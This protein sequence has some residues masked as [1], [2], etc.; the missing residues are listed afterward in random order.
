ML[1]HLIFGVPVLEDGVRQLETRWGVRAQPGGH[2]QGLGTHNALLGLGEGAY[3][4]LIAPDPDQPPPPR[5]RPFGLDAL[6]HP[7]LVAWAVRADD[8]DR[9]VAH[10]RTQ[11]YDPGDPLELQRTTARGTP[12][13]WRLTP[14]ALAGGPIPFLI[15]WGDAIHPSTSAPTGLTLVS[16]HL[17]HPQPE[18][19]T[20]VLDALAVQAAV[21]RG[22][23]PALVARIDGPGSSADLR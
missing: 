22:P 9:R 15:D 18:V 14:K 23:T 19:L 10:A 21:V 12:L 5:P 13:R 6:D 3:L 1:D 16:F 20:R 4:E 11:G 8:L 7:R 2:H 17:E